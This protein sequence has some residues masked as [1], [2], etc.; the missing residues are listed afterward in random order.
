MRV[1]Y[2]LTR[3]WRCYMLLSFASVLTF[4][5]YFISQHDPK[6]EHYFQYN[7]YLN[8]GAAMEK[9]KKLMVTNNLDYEFINSNSKFCFNKLDLQE[10]MALLDED[11]A[12]E[13]LSFNSNSNNN[14]KKYKIDLILLIISQ[15]NNFRNRHVIRNTW[16]KQIRANTRFLFVIGNTEFNNTNN[17]IESLK[18]LKDEIQLYNDIVQINMPDNDNYTPTK[19]LIAIRWSLTYCDI[20]KNL[21]ILSDSAVLNLKLFY[22]RIDLNKISNNTI[23]GSCNYTD[24]KFA[25][26]LKLFFDGIYKKTKKEQESQQTVVG[27]EKKQ[28]DNNKTLVGDKKLTKIYKGEYCSNLGWL[29][30]LSSA[31]RLWLAALRS[32][33]IMKISPAFLNGYLAFKA[34]LKHSSQFVYQD[35]VPKDLNCL[36]VLEQ[37]KNLIA[38][39]E[40]F[41]ITNRFN[42]FIATWNN[43]P[44]QTQ[45]G[46]SKL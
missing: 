2:S 6:L 22:D 15:A 40:N 20:A 19:T 21:F 36:K 7:F 30:S 14:N 44:A 8:G 4:F 33:Y 37:S 29:L 39:A 42:S 3:C 31:K 46:L 11:L 18:K 26:G 45:F 5:L 9:I 43:V 17:K 10:D 12:E 28:T 38:C 27:V 35:M 41:T 32:N 25:S 1:I 16:S 24:S 23:V 34:D 13:S